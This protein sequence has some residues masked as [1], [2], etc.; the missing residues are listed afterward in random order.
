VA[1]EI[2]R[3]EPV[4]EKKL[5]GFSSG[6]RRRHMYLNSVKNCRLMMVRITKAL[7]ADEDDIEPST[8]RLILTY[9]QTIIQTYKLEDEMSLSD[10]LA[11]LK[12]RFDA[13]E[14]INGQK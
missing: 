10:R 11:E 1:D 9:L 13:R 12:E 14:A 7:Y 3:I 2:A 5:K 4:F 6:K 8:A